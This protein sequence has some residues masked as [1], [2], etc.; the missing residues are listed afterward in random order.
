ML[1]TGTVCVPQGE[2]PISVGGV[3]QGIGGNLLVG[4]DLYPFTAVLPVFGDALFLKEGKS[5]L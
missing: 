4:P 1:N 5:S 2:N 3:L